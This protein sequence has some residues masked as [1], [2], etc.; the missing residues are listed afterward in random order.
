[1]MD[2]VTAALTTVM[3]WVGSVVTALTSSTGSLNALLPLLAIGIACSAFMF[4]IKAIRKVC[5]GA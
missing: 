3:M 5:W 4:A 1:M 2:A